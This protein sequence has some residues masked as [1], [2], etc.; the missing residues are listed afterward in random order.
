MGDHVF[1][2]CVG[3]IFID[4]TVREL[5][6][7]YYGVEHGVVVI[8]ASDGAVWPKCTSCDFGMGYDIPFLYLNLRMQ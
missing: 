1:R 3:G 7:I 5:N 6:F 4:V 2:N 8:P